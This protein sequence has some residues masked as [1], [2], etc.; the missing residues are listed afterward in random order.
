[1]KKLSALV[2]L[3]LL[4][5]GGA[6]EVFCEEQVGVDS[7]PFNAELSVVSEA[8]DSGITTNGE[9]VGPGPGGAPG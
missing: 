2:F 3:A 5:I 6:A 8:I 4:L 7:E 9:G 1:M